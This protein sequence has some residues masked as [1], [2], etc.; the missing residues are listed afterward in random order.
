M[1]ELRTPRLLIRPLT[2][3]DQD[4]YVALYADAG[5]M[6]HVGPPLSMDEC[7]KA[8]ERSL[9][10]CRHPSPLY[11]LWILSCRAPAE[12]S[13]GDVGLIG[14][15]TTAP[16]EAEIGV[17]LLPPAQARGFASEAIAHL[18][19]HAFGDLG[20]DRLHTRHAEGHAAARALMEKLGFSPAAPD[21]L[22]SRELRWEMHRNRWSTSLDR[23]AP[24]N[25]I[26]GESVLNLLPKQGEK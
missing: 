15:Q 25:G 8:F 16:G 26:K 21:A 1:R 14:L 6:R 5:V 2:V 12:R 20:F 19:D 10:L 22:E 23:P 17:L 3:A 18:A 13:S 11:W 9:R 4:F 24:Q 7:A